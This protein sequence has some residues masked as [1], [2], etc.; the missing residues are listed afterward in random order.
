MPNSTQAALGGADVK[1]DVPVDRSIGPKSGGDGE[2]FNTSLARK[3][4]EALAAEEDDLES[5]PEEEKE[6]DDG[7]V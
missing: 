7:I 2:A 4:A 3:E 5:L 6:E 1:P